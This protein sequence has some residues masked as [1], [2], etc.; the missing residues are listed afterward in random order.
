MTSPVSP[1]LGRPSDPPARPAAPRP[2]ARDLDRQVAARLR[3][4]RV[5][6]GLTQQQMAERLG[7]TYQQLHKYEAGQNRISAGRLLAIAQALGVEVGYFF[8]G[9]GHGGVRKPAGPQR[10]LLELAR[11]FA[12]IPCRAHQ[13]ALCR[14]A[15]SM[16][17]GEGDREPVGVGEAA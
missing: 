5:A 15:R 1:A 13:E 3:E 2:R 4:R 8:D 16:A 9:Q 7:V 12:L 10:L 14:L 11:N 17:E 6:L